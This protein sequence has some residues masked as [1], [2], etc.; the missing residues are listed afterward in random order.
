MRF[1]IP[2]NASTG[3]T[4]RAIRSGNTGRAG[5]A[6]RTSAAGRTGATRR[7][8][9][10]K[11]S[12]AGRSGNTSISRVSGNAGR[13]GS[14]RMP[15]VI[16]NTGIAAFTAII[17]TFIILVIVSRAPAG[18]AAEGLAE[19]SAPP[20][21]SARSAILI[22]ADT[23]EIVFEKGADAPREP[24]KIAQV[25]TAMMALEV[26][27]P[28]DVLTMDSE[29]YN[30]RGWHMSLQTGEE[31]PVGDLLYAIMLRFMAD[32]PVALAKAISETVDDF[33]ILMN[34]RAKA[35]GCNGTTFV[36][37]DGRFEEEQVSTVHD[38][39]LIVQA[40]MKDERLRAYVSTAEYTIPATNK[41]FERPLKNMNI[42]TKEED[43][44]EDEEAA[45]DESLAA[46]L[47]IIDMP[48]LKI[49]NATGVNAK[50]PGSQT[51][52]LIASGN[53]DGKSYLALVFI[54]EP[55]KAEDE[56]EPVNWTS[57]YLDAAALLEYGFN[58]M[59]EIEV[60]GELV[61]NG[62]RVEP[63]VEGLPEFIMISAGEARIVELPLP[64]VEIWESQ[65]PDLSYEYKF[66]DGLEAPI[67]ARSVI[68]TISAKAG[69]EVIAE[70]DM[71]ILDEIKTERLGFWETVGLGSFRPEGITFYLQV[72]AAI[73]IL[74]VVIL[75]IVLIRHRYTHDPY[76]RTVRY[77][78]TTREIKRVRRLR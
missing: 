62:I 52:C 34:E 42:V 20:E 36:N 14:N 61:A 74:L 54:D 29:V 8:G 31:I 38:L 3:R 58:R 59:G 19:P 72:G 28:D 16:G 4:G 47:S 68:G 32:P 5:A 66:N 70:T 75:L 17:L 35:L 9:V 30:V 24:G 45:P 15:R 78:R 23:G 64:I 22:D 7:A 53:R 55:D 44:E 2:N 50:R 41:Y 71:I 12:A 10:G 73:V 46:L 40:A 1:S 60:F 13:S 69:D 49:D 51:A 33:V 63:G 18:L 39:A 25:M 11:T 56:N 65:D 21:L 77:G 26:L 57:E 27:S 37:T 43:D 48:L 76:V 67:E 6:G